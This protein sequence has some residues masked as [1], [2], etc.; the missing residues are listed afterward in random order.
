MAA[1]RCPSSNLAQADVVVSVEAASVRSCGRVDREGTCGKLRASAGQQ[2]QGR[3][4]LVGGAA[5]RRSGRSCGF[6]AFTTGPMD[7]IESVMQI[8]QLYLGR[9]LTF[10]FLIDK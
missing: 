6:G 10:Y 9:S 2:G 8:N 5:R 3:G 4:V 7:S 1:G